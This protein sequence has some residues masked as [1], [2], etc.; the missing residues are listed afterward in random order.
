[1]TQATASQAVAYGGRYLVVLD[2]HETDRVC[3]IIRRPAAG[4]GDPDPGRAAFVER[5]GQAASAGFEPERD[6]QHIGLA[7]QTTMLMSESLEI[8]EM[9]KAAMLERYGATE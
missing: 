3:D 6:L 9:L 7:N 8:G 5:F 4:D 1:E 2:R